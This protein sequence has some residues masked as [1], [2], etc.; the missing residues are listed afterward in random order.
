MAPAHRSGVEDG[1]Y[2]ARSSPRR[3][4]VSAATF[5]PRDTRINSPRFNRCDSQRAPFVI[6]GGSTIA[7]TSSSENV[8]ISSLSS[9]MTNALACSCTSGDGEATKR[10]KRRTR[11]TR[12]NL[13]VTLHIWIRRIRASAHVYELAAESSFRGRVVAQRRSIADNSLRTVFGN[14]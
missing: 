4:R 9:V 13:P 10:T 1:F 11:S 3:Q 5:E 7:A 6:S 12:A 8:L 2:A 14:P